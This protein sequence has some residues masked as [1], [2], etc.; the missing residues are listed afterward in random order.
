MLLYIYIYLIISLIDA[1]VGMTAL[2]KRYGTW[3]YL[4]SGL[5]WPLFIVYRVYRITKF[6]VWVAKNSMGG[7]EQ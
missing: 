5:L 2:G 6:I 3:F 1:I 4:I 7:K